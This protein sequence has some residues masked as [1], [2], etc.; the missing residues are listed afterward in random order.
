M[1]QIHCAYALSDMSQA[2]FAGLFVICIHRPGASFKSQ[3][4]TD[5]FHRRGQSY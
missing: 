4:I 1:L 3:I 2:V 5:L